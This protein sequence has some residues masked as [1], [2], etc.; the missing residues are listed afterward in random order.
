MVR[1]LPILLLATAVGCSGLGPEDD[2]EP[3][4]LSGTWRGSLV[5]PG[6]E[7]HG[8]TLNVAQVGD[9]LSGSFSESEVLAN[10]RVRRTG[11]SLEGVVLEDGRADVLLSESRL[12][13]VRLEGDRL[14]GTYLVV[15]QPSLS[16]TVDVER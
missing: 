13:K 1:M 2:P 5:T 11:G 8:L 9:E 7:Q 3:L 12:C 16:G 4:D 10:G 15:S 6:G 14:V